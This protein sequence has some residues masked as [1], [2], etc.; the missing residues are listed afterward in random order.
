MQFTGEKRS[1]PAGVDGAAAR[2]R[3]ALPARPR[4]LGHW[5]EVLERVARDLAARP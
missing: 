5:C 2:S 3:L 4:R 1:T